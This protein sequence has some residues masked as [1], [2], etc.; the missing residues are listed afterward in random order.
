M[1]LQFARAP[2]DAAR[3]VDERLSRPST[4]RKF[5][6]AREFD[7]G[8]PRIDRPHAVYDL[9]ARAVAGGGGLETAVAS[10]IR[11]LIEGGGADPAAAEVQID[12]TGAAIVLAHFN[13]GPYASATAR[14]LAQVAELPAV[15]AA[16][17]EVRLLRLSA[18]ALMALWLKAESEESDIIYPL[19]PSPPGIQAER[20]YSAGEFFSAIRP[21]AQ[22]RASNA[23]EGRVP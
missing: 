3:L 10:V 13:Y 17:Y 9:T 7:F 22:A 20:T 1:P 16:A 21:L 11:F 4:R 8:T 6:V 14:A 5:L 18:I 19:A 15:A 23:E 2:G 12:G